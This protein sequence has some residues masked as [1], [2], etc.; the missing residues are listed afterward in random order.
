MVKDEFVGKSETTLKCWQRSHA[1]C[2]SS[3]VPVENF[4]QL[5]SSL[6]FVNVVWIHMWGH[7]IVVFSPSGIKCPRQKGS[8]HLTGRNAGPAHYS[9]GFKPATRVVV[10][11][12]RGIKVGSWQFCFM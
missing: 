4:P 9:V 5:Q 6:T 7:L 8:L 1:V 11:E 2:G 12:E 10:E 3:I